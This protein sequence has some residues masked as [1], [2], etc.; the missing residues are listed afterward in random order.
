MHLYRKALYAAA[1]A[2]VTAMAN[3]FFHF[4]ML[5]DLYN[6]TFALDAGLAGANY[7]YYVAEACNAENWSPGA[8]RRYLAEAGAS[9]LE[10]DVFV[11]HPA[12]SYELLKSLAILSYPELAEAVLYQHE[13]SDGGGFPRGVRK[14]QVSGWE[15]VI[16]FADSLVEILPEYDFETRVVEYLVNFKNQ[17]Q[18]ELPVNRVFRKLRLTLEYVKNLKETGS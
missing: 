10:M 2:V 3:D 6:I 16:I 14:S 7:S 11:G 15:A 13:L 1:F 5:R 17:K 12:R 4:L 8:G 9:E 18:E